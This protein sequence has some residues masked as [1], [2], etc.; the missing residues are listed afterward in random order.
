L[1]FSPHA[2]AQTG[3]MPMAKSGS[4]LKILLWSHFVPA[5]DEWFDKYAAAWGEKNKVEVKVDHIRNA[6]IPARLAAEASA[7]A[8]HDLFEF[9]AVIQANTY[10]DKLVDLTDIAD[11]V[12]KQYGGWVDI[13]RNIGVFGQWRALM[14]Y[15]IVQP[16]I[17]RVD[18]FKEVGYDKFPEDYPT[19][20]EASAKLK[21]KDH[22]CGLPLANCNDGN[23]NWRSVLYSFGGAEQSQ[24]GKQVTIAS[25]ETLAAIKYGVE[26]YNRG[27]TDE[28]FSWDDAGNNRFLLSGRGAWIDNATSAYITARKDAPDVFTNSK[29]GLQP[30]GPGAKGAAR[31]G[32]DANAWAVW[33]WA[34]DPD[35]AKAFIVDWYAQWQEWGKVTDGYNSPPLNDMWKKPM[36]GLED[37]NFQIMQEWK[38]ISFVAGWQGPFHKAIEEING[39][40]VVPNMFA[41]AARGETPDAAMKWAD[42]EYKRIFQKH[43]IG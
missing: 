8:G 35:T 10:E 23:H 2:A 31:N 34:N 12:G 9:Q 16:H 18:Y 1:F 32:V 39:T 29:I 43:G 22:P 26:L 6:D 41:R 36:P 24:D 25:D 19:L 3:P 33:K 38:D 13:A 20:L 42:E 7:G 37:P 5:Y 15:M 30:K 14:T 28:V 27:M 11:A 17:Y 4:S 40:F 21:E